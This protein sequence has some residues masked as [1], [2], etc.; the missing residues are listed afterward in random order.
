MV[1]TPTDERNDALCGKAVVTGERDDK[2]LLAASSA[3]VLR[4]G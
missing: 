4:R 1:P 3:R 2:V